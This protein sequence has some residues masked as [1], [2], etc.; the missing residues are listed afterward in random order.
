MNRMA[1]NGA[2]MNKLSHSKPGPLVS[3]ERTR[4]PRRVSVS[5]NWTSWT[6]LLRLPGMGGVTIH[7][8]QSQ[9]RANPTPGNV[10]TLSCSV[11]CHLPPSRSS[12]EAGE[13][14]PNDSHGFMASI[15]S[16]VW[17]LRNNHFGDT[18]RAE[19]QIA[20]KK[21]HRNAVCKQFL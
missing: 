3:A 6:S 1:T 18:T 19:L 17:R 21:P 16:L 14:R 10:D 11:E 20:I 7:F 4:C 8:G 15:D 13:E 2:S 5:P 12:S 9:S